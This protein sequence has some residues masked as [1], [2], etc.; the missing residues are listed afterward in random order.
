MCGRFFP[1]TAV[2]TYDRVCAL[3][4]HNGFRDALT[5]ICSTCVYR[6]SSSSRIC[7]SSPDRWFNRQ[8]IPFPTRRQNDS[9]F[10]SNR[11]T[12]FRFTERLSRF[13]TLTRKRDV[14]NG[15]Q[16]MKC[17]SDI[18]FANYEIMENTSI[19]VKYHPYLDYQRTSESYEKKGSISDI[20]SSHEYYLAMI[21]R[22]SG[23]G[24]DRNTGQLSWFLP[25]TI[26]Q[27][28]WR[29][30]VWVFQISRCSYQRLWMF[31]QLP[32]NKPRLLIS[33]YLISF[34]VVHD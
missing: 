22:K 17:L 6:V 24:N 25:D 34:S 4:R 20:Y 12:P 23:N 1:V 8:P 26:K 13:W 19:N 28:K 3:H 31:V 29:I 11:A 32:G 14:L 15:Y 2:L 7:T 27:L 33:A 30:F 18:L 9:Y 10:L 5:S 16:R 21:I